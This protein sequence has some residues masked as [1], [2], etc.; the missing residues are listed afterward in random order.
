MGVPIDPMTEK[1]AVARIVSEARHG[2]GGWVV[3]PN[4]DYLR[5]LH[6]RPNLYGIT[7]EASLMLA[8]GMPLVWA[9]RLQG[10]PLPMRVAGSDLSV[11]LAAAAAGAGL[12]I[13]LLGG[14][15]GAAEGTAK[16]LTSRYPALR[17]AG[18]LC[19]PRGFETNQVE[20]TCLRKSVLS[21]EPDIVYSCFGFPK[22]IWV[23][24]QL[25]DYLPKTWFLGLGGSLSMVCGELPRAPGWMQKTGLEWAHRLLLE[26]RR[27][28]KRYIVE[29]L[30]FAFRLFA[31][32][33]WQRRRRR[34]VPVHRTASF[35]T[36]NEP[37][38]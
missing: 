23:I 14:N 21:A 8:D 15:P 36:R 25:R 2:R 5:I 28:F 1:Q 35:E 33:I 11:S 38:Q 6:A 26:P 30:P 17:I 34:I 37:S 19:P 18:T 27:L 32:A 16:V 10:N 29:D 31:H 4:L 24:R 13:F 22:E 12:S 7:A 3:T 20:M 9:S